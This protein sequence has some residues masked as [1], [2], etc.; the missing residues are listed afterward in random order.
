MDRIRAASFAALFTITL[1]SLASAQRQEIA[2][3]SPDSALDSNIVARD[4]TRAV[5]AEVAGHVQLD[6]ARLDS[7]QACARDGPRGD[8]AG[9]GHDAARHGRAQGDE[10]RR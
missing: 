1:T 5:V 6:Q 10:R 8:A 9:H 4:S 7:L 2:T 3:V